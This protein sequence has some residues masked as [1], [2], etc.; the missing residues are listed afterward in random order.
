MCPP[1]GQRNQVTLFVLPYIDAYMYNGLISL[2]YVYRHLS[3]R[4]T[5]VRQKHWIFLLIKTIF[6]KSFSAFQ[7]HSSK[8][9]CFQVTRETLIRASDTN[10]FPKLHFTKKPLP[11]HVL[12]CSWQSLYHPYCFDFGQLPSE[13][14]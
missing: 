2:Y 7:H 8:R 5:S 1:V 9:N 13:V 10:T 11:I 12:C 4:I 6:L 14:P 3:F